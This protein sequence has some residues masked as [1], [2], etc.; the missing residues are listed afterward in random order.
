MEEP[1]S[2]CRLVLIKQDGSDG[3]AFCPDKNKKNI[4]VG[5]DPSCDIRIQHEEAHSQ[6][7][8]IYVGSTGKIKL[9]NLFSE[10]AVLVNNEKVPG[11]RQLKSGDVIDLLGK[12]MRWESKAEARRRNS[13]LT[14]AERQAK[15]TLIKTSR[16]IT[17]RKINLPSSSSHLTDNQESNKAE[18]AKALT[19]VKEEQKKDLTPFT[20]PNR[21]EKDLDSSKN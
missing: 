11:K 17:I 14:G 16:R 12:K 19:P 3:I 13:M 21:N 8:L 20:T 5:S 15:K 6:H 9:S 1:L 10:K 4:S 7:F 2:N 18:E